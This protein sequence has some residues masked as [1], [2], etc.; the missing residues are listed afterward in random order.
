MSTTACVMTLRPTART[1]S[2][3]VR[4]SST[5]RGDGQARMAIPHHDRRSC[6]EPSPPKNFL[7]RD[8]TSASKTEVAA[9]SQDSPRRRRGCRVRASANPCSRRSRWT[10]VARWSRRGQHFAGC[11]EYSVSARQFSPA[12]SAALHASEYVSRASCGSRR[13]P[14][15]LRRGAEAREPRC[16]GVWIRG[17]RRRQAGPDARAA[18]HSAPRVSLVSMSA[19]ETVNGAGLQAQLGGGECSVGRPVKFAALEKG[20][21]ALEKQGAAGER[22]PVMGLVSSAFKLQGNSPARSSGR[23]G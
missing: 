23:G 5:P 11:G 7:D 14:E 13:S 18:V 19:L 6:R 10:L 15:P 20:D 3:A 1:A 17:S 8:I 9:C 12:N 2:P 21:G 4:A 22:G 16:R